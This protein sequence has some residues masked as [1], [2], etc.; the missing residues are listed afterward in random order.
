MFDQGV[1]HNAY[2]EKLISLRAL[3][4]DIKINTLARILELDV[5]ILVDYNLGDSKNGDPCKVS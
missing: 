2:K 3:F 1:E 4:Q 5:S